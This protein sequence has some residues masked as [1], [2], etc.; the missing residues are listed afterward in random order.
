MTLAR[1]AA[2]APRLRILVA[3]AACALLLSACSMVRLGYSQLDNIAAWMADDYFDLDARQKD[4]FA[5]RFERLYEWHRYEQLP[6]YAAFFAQTRARLQKGLAREDVLWFVDGLRARYRALVMRGSE[7]AAALLATIAPA[8]L[9]ALQRQWEKDN[10]RFAREY[11]LDE[12]EEEIKRAR[13]R[14]TLDQV[15]DWVGSLTPEQEQRIALLVNDLP[16]T[17]RL[18]HADR[19]RRQ[20][21]F[22]KL[23]AQRVNRERFPAQLRQWLID[24]EDGRAPEY[25]QRFTEWFEK[26]VQM[27]V[28]IDRMLTSRQRAHAMQR[29]AD[30]A[31]DFTKLAERLRVQTARQP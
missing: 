4:E 13:V 27:A 8:Q 6:D 14:R 9:E 21:E 22:L 18:R 1:P 5:K 19:V 28:A 30:F 3:L 2:S 31:D 17:E 24:W 10:R 23:M 26:R 20:R 16:A 15:K 12:S 11:R 7:D 25:R 29:L